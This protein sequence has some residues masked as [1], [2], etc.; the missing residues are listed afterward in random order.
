MVSLQA[1]LE[2][3]ASLIR[4][5]DISS[6]NARSIC[7]YLVGFRALSQFRIAPLR[8]RD[9]RGWQPCK[10]LSVLE[11]VRSAI[12]LGNDRLRSRIATKVERSLSTGFT[13]A[14]PKSIKVTKHGSSRR[15]LL[16]GSFNEFAE[17]SINI[18]PGCKSA[19]V[20]TKP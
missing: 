2:A 14:Q 20:Y 17:S 1:W 13:R 8:T 3:F 18:F 19:W 10:L 4:I 9:E 5:V 6:Q 7:L 16:V 15:L 11:D 12:D